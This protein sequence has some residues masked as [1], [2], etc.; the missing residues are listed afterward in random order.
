MKTRK[1]NTILGI[2]IAAVVLMSCSKSEDLD[3]SFN[4]SDSQSSAETFSADELQGLVYVAEIKKLHRDFYKSAFSSTSDKLFQE[5]YTSDKNSLNMITDVLDNYGEVRKIE[6]RGS[7]DYIL[8][9]TQEQAIKIS[10]ISGKDASEILVSAKQLEESLAEDILM[11]LDKVQGNEDIVRL[12]NDLLTELY[13][14]LDII[15][16]NS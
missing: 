8:D 9:N 12:Y 4:N 7:G 3:Q 6:N 10:N 5:L 1:L 16:S 13:K 11:N 2:A 14:Q 15:N